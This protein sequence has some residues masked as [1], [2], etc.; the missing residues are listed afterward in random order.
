V[1]TDL[2]ER[3]GQALRAWDERLKAVVMGEETAKVVHLVQT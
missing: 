1:R 2:L 3:K